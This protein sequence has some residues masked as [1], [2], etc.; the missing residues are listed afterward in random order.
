[1]H[2]FDY[3]E[4]KGSK[5]IVRKAEKD[6]KF[7]TLDE[8]EYKLNDEILLICDTEKPVALAGVMGGLNSG[9]TEKTTDI[10]LEVAYFNLAD[11]R[12]A[13]KH[14][15]IFTDSSK[16][17]ERGVD[18]NDAQFVIDRAILLMQELAGGEIVAGTN[19]AYPTKIEEKNIELRVSRATQILGFEISK[20]QMIEELNEI[21]L[22][23]TADESDD[24]IINVIVPTFRGDIER[25]SDFVR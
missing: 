15:S 11:I 16:R 1:M 4:V 19:D 5:I 2:A 20:E 23:A 3:S 25:A 14:L 10:L 18:P 6:E 17:F 7:V 13:V 22:V 8:A 21:S 12:H 24:N 9:V